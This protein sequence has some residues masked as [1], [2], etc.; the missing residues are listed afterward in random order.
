MSLICKTCAN[1]NNNSCGTGACQVGIQRT[2]RSIQRHRQRQQAS[3]EQGDSAAVARH[4]QAIARLEKK[5]F[6]KL[7]RTQPAP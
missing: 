6:D 2:Q 7:D 1:R 5:L 4:Q 3:A